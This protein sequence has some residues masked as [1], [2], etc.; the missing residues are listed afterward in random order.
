[1][2]ILRY[3]TLEELRGLSLSELH[4]L[5]ELV[6]TDRQRAYKAAYEREVRTAGAVGS[7]E[8]ERQVAAELLKRYDEAALV[9]VGSRWARTPG[10]VQDAA[11]QNVVLDAP[12]DEVRPTS[13]KPSPKVMLAVGLAALL[14]FG[15]MFTRLLGGRSSADTDATPEISPTPTPLVSPTPT[16]LALEAQ[17]DVIQG[18]DSGR[19]VAYPVNLQ[20]IL[21]DGDAPRV[22][23]VQRRRVQASEWR[24]DLNPDTASFV[25]GM[26]VRPVIGIPWSEENESYFDDINTGTSFLLT[27]NTGA[28]L[29]FEFDDRREVRRSETSIFRQV[30][31]GLV[32]LLIGQTDDD[33]LP[34]ATRTLVTATYPPEQELSRD[35]QII[36]MDITLQEGSVGETLMMG[37][38]SITLQD[39]QLITDQPDLPAD[40]QYLLLNYEVLAGVEA[41]DTTIWRVEF[42]DAGG[43][44]Y[45]PGSAALTYTD[46]D[47]LPL[48]IP[49]LSS[50]FASVGYIVP[51]TLQSG[52]WIVTDTA[53]NGVS[54]TLAFATEPLDLHYDGVDV[55][56]V[57]VTHLEGQIT[58]H[59]RIYNGRTEML[60]FTQDDIWMAL[61]YAPE[62]P[63][64]RNP[65]EGLTPFDLLP[66]QAVDLTLVWYWGGEPYASM[67]VG[68]YRFAIQLTRGS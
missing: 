10:R 12:E 57:S 65:A 40:S 32:L 11:K 53:G 31:P 9:P 4:A 63:G 25:N 52:R 3:H 64:P 49:A 28:V 41:L 26:S 20:V 30:S 23:V 36:G 58:T 22:W 16:P 61:G 8:L 43:Q 17:D 47:A 42:V 29:R 34:T 6:L 60:H 5:W 35:G 45:T 38:A 50:L 24:F 2:D 48:E 46:F 33:G 59:L 67:G 19:E 37:D 21:P 62:P 51:D 14:F 1:M 68:E 54:F 44:I 7:D 39:A 15:F 55:R 27:M 13:G 18:G 66:E 56:L